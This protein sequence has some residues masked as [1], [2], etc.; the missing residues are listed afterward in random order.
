MA[1]ERLDCD[2]CNISFDALGLTFEWSHVAGDYCIRWQG[3]AAGN[4]KLV[5][6]TDTIASGLNTGERAMQP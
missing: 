5:G 4:C 2:Y 3:M 1:A 6:E